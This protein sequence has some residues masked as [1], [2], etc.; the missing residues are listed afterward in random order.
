MKDIFEPLSNDE[1]DWLDRFII[2]RFNEDADVEGKDEGVLCVSELDGLL[3][4]VVSGPVLVPPSKW[5]PQVWGDFQPAWKDERE[6]EKVMSLMMRHMNC[7]AAFLMEQPEDFEPMFEES[8]V[9]GKTY[10]IVDE[11]C[12]GYIRGV[13]LASEQG[14][15]D[16]LQQHI[17]RHPVIQLLT[18]PLCSWRIRRDV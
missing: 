8:D 4:A 6:V 3:T 11:W 7:I 2:Y 14:E 12:E 18:I 9:D 16:T 10:T 15:L 5:L 13:A 17:N 1:L